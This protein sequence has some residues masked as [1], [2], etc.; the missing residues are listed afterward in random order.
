MGRL[1]AIVLG[2]AAGGA[3]PQWNCRCP[4]CALAWAGDSRVTPR[5]QT[6]IA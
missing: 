2:S 5:T 4:V 3:F 1:T 6:G